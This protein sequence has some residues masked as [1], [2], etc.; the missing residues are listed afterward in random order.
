MV[1]VFSGEGSF[2]VDG[3]YG[4][5][6][7]VFLVGLHL[8]YCGLCGGVSAVFIDEVLCDEW[9]CDEVVP[10]GIEVVYFLEKLVFWHDVCDVLV[11]GVC[12]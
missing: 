12:G 2:W 11:E 10:C 3:L 7:G 1:A 9:F 8:L 4:G 6:Y 5:G